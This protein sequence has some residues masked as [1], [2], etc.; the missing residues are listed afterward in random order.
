MILSWPDAVLNVTAKSARSDLA[1]PL[2][3]IEKREIL[4]DLEVAEIVPVTD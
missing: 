2:G 3:V 4:L 1:K